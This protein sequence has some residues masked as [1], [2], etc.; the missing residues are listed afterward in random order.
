MNTIIGTKEGI[1]L[2]GISS[3][4]TPLPHFILCREEGQDRGD[5]MSLRMMPVWLTL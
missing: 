3:Q 5:G 2:I 1:I 4:R